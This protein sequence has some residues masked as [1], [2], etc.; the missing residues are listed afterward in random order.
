[1]KSPEIKRI[2]VD[3][4][5]PTVNMKRLEW[6][7]KRKVLKYGTDPTNKSD[8]YVGIPSLIVCSHHTGKEIMFTVIEENDVLFDPDQ[9]DGEQQIY[10]PTSECNV[11]HL[12]IYNRG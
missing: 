1:M 2:G 3:M 4:S 6:D 7:S 9:W 10:R 12:V 5:I 8:L 11:D